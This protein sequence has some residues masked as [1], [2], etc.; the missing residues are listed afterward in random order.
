MHQKLKQRNFI[1]QLL[2][3]NEEQKEIKNI[4]KAQ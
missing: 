1:G 2:K 4:L 3:E